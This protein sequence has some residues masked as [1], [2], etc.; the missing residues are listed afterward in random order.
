MAG[1]EGVAVAAAI[2]ASGRLGHLPWN[3]RPEDLEGLASLAI[4]GKN[5][6]VCTRIDFA[7]ALFATDVPNATDSVAVLALTE[8]GT[9]TA[10][11]EVDKG[12]NT[13]VIT[14][15]Q[16]RDGASGETLR[17]R[18]DIAGTVVTLLDINAFAVAV[19]TVLVLF[20]LVFSVLAILVIVTVGLVRG[21]GRSRG[22]GGGGFG[23]G[24]GAA[25][26]TGDPVPLARTLRR[27]EGIWWLV[28]STAA[29]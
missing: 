19:A 23:W 4:L 3:V 29:L 24:F 5:V 11:I 22:F 1:V 26:G 8:S 25:E 17:T 10:V 20:I 6:A 9:T 28:R 7:S 12:I 13:F 18:R 27:R 21:L 2:E 16:T 15:N 14:T